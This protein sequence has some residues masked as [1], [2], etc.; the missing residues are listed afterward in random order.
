MK[1]QSNT[2]H[3]TPHIQH[4]TSHTHLPTSGFRLPTLLLLLTI[5]HFHLHADEGMWIPLLL[6]K[7]NIQ[8]MQDKGF[9]LTAED[10]YSIN[11]ASLKD[12]VVIFGR[13]CTGELVSDQGL[14]F[15]NHH[16]GYSSIQSLSS[17]ENDY[18][19][20]GYWAMSK[21]EELPV[22]G[23]SVRFL[24][25]IEDVTSKVLNGTNTDINE[26]SKE[27]VLR[28]NINA[29][30]NDAVKGT[31]YSALIR[32]FYYGDEYYMFVYEEY[33]D[34][35]LVGAPPSSIGNFGQD[36]DNWVW[37]RHTG[38][39]SVF[40]I[41]AS[42]DNKPADYSPDNIPYV[43]KKYFPV[44]MKGVQ[45]NDFTMVLG[46]PGS[47]QQYLTSDGLKI[48]SEIKYPGTVSL[49]GKRLEII[50][51]YMRTSDKIRIQYAAKYRRI[52]NYWKKYQ[53]IIHGL[54]NANALEIKLQQE[55]AFTSWVN[56]DPVRKKE[57]GEVLP[58]L[59][60]LY[61]EQIDYSLVD[62]YLQEAFL[63]NEL[64]AFAGKVN[65]F[66]I[67][68]SRLSDQDKAE[69]KI[70]FK[71]EIS[72]FYKDYYQALDRDIFIEMLQS[73]RADV[74]PLFHPDVYQLIDKKYKSDYARFVD[75]TYAKSV[76]SS[77]EKMLE[78]L[79]N[80][81]ENESKILKKISGDPLMEVFNSFATKYREIVFPKNEFLKKEIDKQYRIYVRGLR[82][83]E[84]DK[85]LHPDGNFTMRV[86]YGNVL[87]YSPADAVIYEYSSNLS[88][89]IEKSQ[90]GIPDYTIP[91]ELLRLYESKDYG[92]YANADGTMPVCFIATNHTSNGNSGSPVISAD[93]YLIGIN[94]DRNWEGT[95]SDLEY[96]ISQC[97]N[98]SV[99]VRY[100]LFIIDK[101]AGAGY[102]L[103][104]ME[105]IRGN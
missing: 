78:W 36:T 49:R 80:Y 39:F 96:D 92:R 64:L 89:L 81:P 62:E 60:R 103:D 20:N 93:G 52:S 58:D 41:Y 28:N 34:I 37:P 85:V 35:R 50:Y 83:M 75:K 43:P 84:K 23:L 11:Q 65:N 98:I 47:T 16:C 5:F 66:Y 69:A 72:G 82:E 73:F 86:T 3:P 97:R 95:M 42:T 25:R 18:L 21:G 61:G 27:D 12:A 6:E 91:N 4:P 15:T 88:G 33:T 10:I 29:I 101:F 87:G 99:D 32:P 19:T 102:L 74:D 2:P 79:D 100:V 13:G 53:G 9:K 38:D 31:N 90:M 48:L 22:P 70:K 56:A 8:D 26:I 24:V 77:E 71:N 54:K 14:L 59:Q 7:Y 45:E 17:V 51:N 105:I 76:F 55:E 94:F 63:A 46:Y 1:S 68:N 104:E 57:Y 40:R 67:S 30:R 44:S